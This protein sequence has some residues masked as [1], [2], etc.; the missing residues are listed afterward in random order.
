MGKLKHKNK[1]QIDLL[2]VL[3]AINGTTTQTLIN[4]SN[5]E[6]FTY[7]SLNNLSEIE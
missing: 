6:S 3:S 4:L 5:I 7:G 2:F 1:F